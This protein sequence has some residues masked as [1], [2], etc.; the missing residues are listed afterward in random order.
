MTRRR[1][2]AGGESSRRSCGVRGPVAPR[3]GLSGKRTD[4]NSTRTGTASTSF[5]GGSPAAA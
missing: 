4:S 2:V 1:L 5:D 3:S